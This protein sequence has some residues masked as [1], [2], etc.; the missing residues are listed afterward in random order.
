[1]V[2]VLF[3]LDQNDNRTKTRSSGKRVA[4]ADADAVVTKQ[5]LFAHCGL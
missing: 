4:A 2:L 5:G 3:C 1:M